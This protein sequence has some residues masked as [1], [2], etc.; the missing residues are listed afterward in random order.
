MSRIEEILHYSAYPSI[1]LLRDISTDRV[2]TLQLCFVYRV[3]RSWILHSVQRD[4][5]WQH[6][7]SLSF[8][9]LCDSGYETHINHT[10]L[11]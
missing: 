9:G 7:S 6:F 8:S 10:Q 11:A 2:R 1:S 3:N 5:D 4:G